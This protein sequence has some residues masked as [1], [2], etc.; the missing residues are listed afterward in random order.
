MSEPHTSPTGRE[1]DGAPQDDLTPFVG[2]AGA[3]SARHDDAKD[4]GALASFVAGLSDGEAEPLPSPLREDGLDLSPFVTA[5]PP[6]QEPLRR[7]SRPGGGRR[8]RHRH[9]RQAA[10]AAIAAAAL[11]VVIVASLVLLD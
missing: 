6:A 1:P 2:A 10:M 8:R 9:R 3:S 11:L 5:E 7:R 4:D